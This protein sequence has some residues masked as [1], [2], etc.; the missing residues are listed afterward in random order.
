MMMKTMNIRSRFVEERREELGVAL[1]AALML[2]LVFAVLG[3]AYMKSMMLSLETTQYSVQDARA[4]HLGRAGIYAG[5]GEIQGS[6]SAGERPELRYTLHTLGLPILRQGQPE[7]DEYMQDV[8][9]DVSDELARVDLNFSPKG[10]LVE[11]GIPGDVVDAYR[12][13]ARNG[14]GVLM[15]VSELW[16]RGY[17]DRQAFGTLDRDLF[18]VHAGVS[19]GHS[20]INLNSASPAVLAAVFGIEEDAAENLVR[21]FESWADA[22]SKVGSDSVSFNVASGSDMPESLV[23]ES[24]V[25]RLSSSMTLITPYTTSQ[26]ISA[27]VDAVVQFGADG[28]YSLLYWNEDPDGL[29]DARAMVSES[30]DDDMESSN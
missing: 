8:T 19:H 14:N 22:V 6:M 9:V 18:T 23:L 4:T 12:S 2:L 25:Y 15:S 24:R 7:P 29:E 16:S 11:L 26:G 1:M 5:I 21:P 10:V 30:L 20:G 28:G 13:D 17:L 3:T 27:A